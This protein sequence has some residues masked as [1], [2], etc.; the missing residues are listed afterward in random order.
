MKRINHFAW[1]VRRENVAAYVRKFESL[2]DTEFEL[3]SNEMVDAYVNWDS[4]LEFLAP[5]ESDGGRINPLAKFLDERGEG[6]YALV[7]RVPDL[8]LGSEEARKAGFDVAPE[9]TPADRAQRKAVID[10]YTTKL[11]DIRETHVGGFLGLKLALCE[12]TYTNEAE[13]R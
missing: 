4:G 13:R 10:S 7:I 8:D 1:L 2:L 3:V 9:S 11:E 6:P 5:V 12:L